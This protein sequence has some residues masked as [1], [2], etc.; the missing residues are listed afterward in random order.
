M[1]DASRLKYLK[2]ALIVFGSIC[3]AGLYIMMQAW[4]AGWVWSP[5]QHEYEQMIMGVYA[6][7]GVFLII[8]AKAP[9]QHLSLI[10]FT[11]WS[12]F[13]HGGIMLIQALL[14][15]KER[16]HLLGDIPAL[17]L[18]GVVLWIFIPRTMKSS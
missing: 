1:T 8:A 17:F 6:T 11:I 14:D 16:S 15:V 12:S 4:P 9:L 10:R 7:L 18:M 13:I 3:I 2:I 5:A